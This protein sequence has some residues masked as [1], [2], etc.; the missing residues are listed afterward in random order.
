MVEKKSSV[1]VE[2]RD[3]MDRE[4]ADISS[5]LV[6]RYIF[7]SGRD[8]TIEEPLRLLVSDGGGHRVFSAEDGGTSYYIDA[9]WI[10]IEWKVKPGHPHFVK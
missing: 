3:A 2:F 1:K 4:W 5:E 6:R 9:G 8:I 10:A 7:P